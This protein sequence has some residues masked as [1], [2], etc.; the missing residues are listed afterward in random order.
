MIRAGKTRGLAVS[1]EKRFDPLPDVPTFKEVG[2]GEA[3]GLTRGNPGGPP[4][5][6]LRIVEIIGRAIEKATK[7]PEF[8]KLVEEELVFK[9]EFKTGQMMQRET[10]DFDKA[11]GPKFAAITQ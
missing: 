11:V 1:T 3:M 4:N 2:I 10:L 6:S 5:M 7:D 9:V 8:V